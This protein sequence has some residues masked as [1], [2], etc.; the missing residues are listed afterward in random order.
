MAQLIE[1]EL[2]SSATD[3]GDG[4]RNGFQETSSYTSLR[5]ENWTRHRSNYM[6]EHV[7]REFRRRKRLVGS[8]VFISPKCSAAGR[9]TTCEEASIQFRNA[10]SHFAS[11]SLLLCRT[12]G[13]KGSRVS[14]TGSY[15]EL[16]TRK[17]VSGEFSIANSNPEVCRK[18]RKSRCFALLQNIGLIE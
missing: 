9:R 17:R 10:I 4:L 3:V 18:T 8:R 6:Q 1:E 2:Q 12:S 16:L 5:R 13:K 14:R 7:M 11:T 15:P